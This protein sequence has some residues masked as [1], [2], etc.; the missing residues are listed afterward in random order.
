EYNEVVERPAEGGD[1]KDWPRIAK[2]QSDL[3]V[4]AF[5][6]GQTR[7]ASYMLTKCQGLSRFPW[8]GHTGQRH[9]EYTH[10][11]VETPAGQRALRDINRWHVEEFAYLMAKLESMP[12]GAGTMLDSTLMVMVHEHAEANAHKNSGLAVLVAGGVGGLKKG[13]HSR[14]AGTIGDLYLT[15][16]S[17]VMKTR[18]EKFPTAYRKLDEIA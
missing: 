11:A 15:L 10:G 13:R 18:I 4:H 12:E 2:L 17:E 3:L 16:A 5:A 8:L 14:I 1:L 6:S 9:H 7:V